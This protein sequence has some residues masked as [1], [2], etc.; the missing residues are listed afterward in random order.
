[1]I[2]VNWNAKFAN[3]DLDCEHLINLTTPILTF[4]H[5]DLMIFCVSAPYEVLETYF[6]KKS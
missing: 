2:V 1:M 5:L 4:A 6:S 3:I